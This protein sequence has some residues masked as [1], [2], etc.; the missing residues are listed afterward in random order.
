MDTGNKLVNLLNQNR[1]E[2][3]FRK[4]AV[5]LGFS[6]AYTT[7]VL[8]GNV[9]PSLGFTVNAARFLAIP[10]EQAFEL[11]G[12]QPSVAQGESVGVTGKSGK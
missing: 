9:K 6:H 5:L 11:A 2:L 7:N 8:M 10:Y 12:L 1:G 4:F 3:S